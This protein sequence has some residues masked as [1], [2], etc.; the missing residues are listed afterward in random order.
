VWTLLRREL[1]VFGS[2]IPS[3]GDIGAFTAVSSLVEV[4]FSGVSD[5]VS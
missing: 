3:Y 4:A 2:Q 5:P 1:L